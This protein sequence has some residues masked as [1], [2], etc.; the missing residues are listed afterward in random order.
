MLGNPGLRIKSVI[1]R[2]LECFKGHSRI[3][4]G[5][6]LCYVSRFSW[7]NGGMVEGLSY[8]GNEFRIF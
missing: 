5:G 8:T 6:V 3:F 4:G 2:T 1:D 7:G